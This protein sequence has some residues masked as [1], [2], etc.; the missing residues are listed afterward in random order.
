MPIGPGKYDDLCTKVRE[1]AKATAAL[2]IIL[3]G[4][5]GRGF[6]VQTEDFLV[7]AK[8][9]AILRNVANQIEETLAK[10]DV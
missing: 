10:G 1:E 2:V 8:L 5:K 3:G 9:P 4:N 7:V 6:S